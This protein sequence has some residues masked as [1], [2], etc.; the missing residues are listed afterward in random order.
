MGPL[1]GL[2]DLVRLE[3]ARADVD[4]LLPAGLV[5][6]PDLL[7]VRVEAP[8]RR[9]HRVAS[10]VAEGGALAAAVTDLGHRTAHGSGGRAVQGHARRRRTSVDAQVLPSQSR[11]N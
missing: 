10:R 3:A 11:E 2:G 1:G 8:A 5:L 9:G 4:A 6:D 7:K